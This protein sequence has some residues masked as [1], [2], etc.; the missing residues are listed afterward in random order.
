VARRFVR[1]ATHPQ[2]QPPRRPWGG[3]GRHRRALHRRAARR[4]R[5]AGAGPGS[6]THPGTNASRRV[7]R[8][9][10]Q[11]IPATGP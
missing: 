3:T 11:P 2:L 4:D 6:A 9:S 8:S 10:P 1:S 5:P 7:T